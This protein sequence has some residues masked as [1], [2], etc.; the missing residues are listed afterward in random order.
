MIW[1]RKST[2]MH[3]FSLVTILM[4]QLTLV[5]LW[6]H[7]F[8]PVHATPETL[9][10]VSPSS[11]I[12]DTLAPET[13]LMLKPDGDGTEIAWTG[14]YEDW[15]DWPTH[16]GDT[17]YVSTTTT[18]VYESSTLEDHTTESWS[19]AR[20][21]VVIVAKDSSNSCQLTPI[22]IT[23]AF[24][25][26]GS[27]HSLTTTYQT[28]T[29]EWGV[30]PET[31]DYWTW[32][33][34]DSLEAG[35]GSITIPGG[36]EIR[37]TQMYVEVSGSRL[38]VDITVQDVTDLWGWQFELSYDPNVIEGVWADQYYGGKRTVVIG[39]FLESDGGFVMVGAGAGWNNTYGKLALTLAYLSTKDPT[40]CPDGDGII[41]TLVFAVVGKGETEIRLDSLTGLQDPEG[42][43]CS[44]RDCVEDGYFRNTNTGN[45]PSVSWTVTPVDTSEPLE[46]YNTTFA[47][48][49]SGGSSPY[50][51]KWYFWER[52]RSDA[53]PALDG[54][55][56]ASTPSVERN[57]TRR[58]A[59]NLTLTVID[60]DGV[61]RS[62][63]SFI[64]IKAHD[65]YITNIAT[66]TTRGMYPRMNATGI[67]EIVGIDVTAKNQGD[68]T[69]TFNV[70]CFWYAVIEGK[71]Q[72]GTIG[73]QYSVT[74]AAGASTLLS[75]YWDTTG[76]NLTHPTYYAI[77][78]NASRVPYEYDIE[79][80][81]GRI[82]P[83]EKPAEDTFRVRVHD[84]AVT[85][86]ATNATMPITPGDIVEVSVTIKNEGDF[87]ETAL[88]VTAYYDN[89]TIATQMIS[90]MTNN[91][92]ASLELPGNDT[93]T[94]IFYWDTTGVPS[95]TYR[96]SARAC[97][98]AVTDDYDTSDNTLVDGIVR[99]P[100]MPEAS[101]TYEP[102]APSVDEL[103]SFN[104]SASNAL[105]GTIVSYEWDF[106][107]G[108][109]D[110]GM[111]VDHDY[112]AAGSYN[113][114]LTVSDGTNSD[115]EKKMLEISPAPSRDISVVEITASPAYPP[116][117]VA[118]GEYVTI[119]VEVSNEG[120]VEEL[121]S[122]NVYYD[123]LPIEMR[124]S[125]ILSGG[126]AK[127]L[128]FK[129]NTLGVLPSVY[130]INATAPPVPDETET[131]DNMASFSSVAFIDE[132]PPSIGT[133][134][135][136]PVGDV[137]PDQDVKVSVSVV[138][139]GSG[140]KNVTLSYSTT[141]GTSWIDLSMTYNSTS[142]LYQATIPG[143]EYCTWVSYKVIAYDNSENLA[144]K[145]NAGEYYVYHVIPEF[146]LIMILPLIIAL[147][148][149]ALILGR[150]LKPRLPTRRAS[151]L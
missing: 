123:S 93:E 144:T 60:N 45:L 132:T 92:F 46:G 137:T 4:A 143:E 73:T 90:L 75:F 66:N 39:P 82:A 19:I 118:V 40:Y 3:L 6:S 151:R 150:F 147:A 51:Y 17:D 138:D 24:P 117:R 116:D 80:T 18:W 91:S 5:S 57:Y 105:M 14:D 54:P 2:W 104:A 109:T 32:S 136:E 148:A 1:R 13:T 36:E 114:T 87:N 81:T 27:I 145:D 56:I 44:G 140:V 34:I 33:D 52:Y 37:V 7:V 59:W 100:L 98:C 149:F 77:H 131:G 23:G 124:P 62:N 67:D 74:L 69:E 47:A 96:I 101:F 79:W 119:S 85:N 125:V 21:K 127:T 30:N 94:L 84:I 58:G 134:A 61:V 15:N 88:S 97:P 86:V 41:A 42:V 99:W 78:A 11:V 108:E 31:G 72:Y 55:I 120:N 107:D 49:V 16:N 63:S 20:V 29:S 53:S 71:G 130:V 89:T 121:F 115:I 146:P 65:V 8:H 129:W 113:V 139:V 12:D 106:G 64:L 68:F 95:S 43:V 122:V 128:T 70:T 35:V 38:T 76:C 133:P 25:S 83:N 141:N 48:V 103:V 26:E 10:S 112:A 50:S 102:S 28:Y 126:S 142:D 22:V 135:R 110:S 111:T 9:V